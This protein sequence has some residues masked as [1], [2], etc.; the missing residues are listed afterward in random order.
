MATGPDERF[1]RDPVVPAFLASAMT[2]R[3]IIA[4]G[5]ALGLSGVA[6]SKFVAEAAPGA[7]GHGLAKLAQDETPKTGG[8][9]K[10]GLQSD[11]SA[12]DPYKDSLTAIWHVVEHIYNRLTGI[13]PD[14]TVKPELAESWDISED[15]LTYTPP[16]RPPRGGF[17][18]PPGGVGGGFVWSVSR[19]GGGPPR[20]WSPP[21]R[22]SLLNGEC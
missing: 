18:S 13:N 22:R 12:L 1:P 15:G 6:L 2:R 14:L 9:L 3:Q 16:P 11:P 21:R 17:L 4:R 10:V 8:I 19:R 5:A 7:P 20:G